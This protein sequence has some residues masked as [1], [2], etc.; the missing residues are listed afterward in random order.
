MKTRTQLIISVPRTG[1][2][3]DF[4]KSMQDGKLVSKFKPADEKNNKAAVSFLDVLQEASKEEYEKMQKELMEQIVNPIMP[5]LYG[6]APGGVDGF[7]GG[8]FPG[9]RVLMCFFFKVDY[10]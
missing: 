1:S 4:R 8:K 9:G 6:G 2:T 10:Q 3:Y 5:K 7:P